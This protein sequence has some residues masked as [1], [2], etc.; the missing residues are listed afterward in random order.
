V[1]RDWRYNPLALSHNKNPPESEEQFRD[2]ASFTS[3]RLIADI[4][5]TYARF[6]LETAQGE[7]THATSLFT[8][9]SR[10]T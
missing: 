2:M 7:Y 3:P 9:P 8:P 5:G 4:G 10:P 6:V 1:A